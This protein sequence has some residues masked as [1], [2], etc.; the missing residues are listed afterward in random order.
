M[1]L[2][3]L[4]MCG[5]TD[6]ARLMWLIRYRAHRNTSLQCAIMERVCVRLIVLPPMISLLLSFSCSLAR[7]VRHAQLKRGGN[8]Y[9]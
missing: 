5:N 3:H 9:E 6:L 8:V 2:R 7:C 4:I 1:S